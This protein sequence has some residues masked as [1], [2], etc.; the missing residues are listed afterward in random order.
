MVK[1]PDCKNVLDRGMFYIY[2]RICLLLATNT[3]V[4]S[5]YRKNKTENEAGGADT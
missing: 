3:F 2:Q 5:P 1:I 4:S